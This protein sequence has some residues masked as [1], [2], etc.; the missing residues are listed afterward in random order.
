[1]GREAST[2]DVSIGDVA[3]MSDPIRTREAAARGVTASQ[4]RGPHW[5]S[6]TYGF[7]R[8][9]GT[10]SSLLDQ[11]RDLLPALPPS[12]VFCHLTAASLYGIWLPPLPD[13]L[14]LLVSLPP[15]TDRPERAGVYAFRSRAGERV[16][17][18]IA[19]VPVLAPE[20]VLGQLA[21]DLSTVDLV[22]AIDGAL[23]LGLCD[24][25]DIEYAIRSR[26]RG[27]PILR[28]A[29]A[30]ADGRSESPWETRLRMVHSASDL[31]VEPQYLIRDDNGHIVARADLRLSDT[32][33]LPEYDGAPHRDRNQ[34]ERDLERDKHLARLGYERYGYIARELVRTPER[35]IRDAED[36]LGLR[37]D[38]WRVVAWLDLAN[39][40]IL[41]R[42][43]KTRL[44]RRLHRFNRPLRGRKA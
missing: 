26:Q 4:L 1:M 43:G 27:L 7:H 6:V 29:I 9:S 37:H 44:L 25:A 17:H 14:P 13:W 42:D 36:A 8:K 2:E 34:H 38:P 31:R 12:S 18:L 19:G 28:R 24:L 22:V 32:W 21:E 33:R 15:A 39:L 3:R 5:E 30:M 23:Q 41:T 11:C 40:S 20:L 35:I 16:P 10:V